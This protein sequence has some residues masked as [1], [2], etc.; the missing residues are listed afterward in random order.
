MIH[1]FNI[2][3]KLISEYPKGNPRP[4]QKN[5]MYYKPTIGYD[6]ET[7]NPI[8]GT[9][10]D[11]PDFDLEKNIDDF[12]KECTDKIN[13][14]TSEIILRG[15]NHTKDSSNITFKYDMIE[16]ANW[17]AM[18]V[19]K[20]AITYPF[21]KRAKNHDEIEFV[22]ENELFACYMSGLA[23]VSNQIKIGNGIKDN[24]R[25]SSNAGQIRNMLNADNRA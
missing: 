25:N 11:N 12:R 19:G 24:I 14:K 17:T 4:F 2:E 5:E 7:N 15:F 23:H 1:Y 20:S 18:A 13:S 8:L 3:D 16:Q 21:K 9:K 10:V 6:T 22:D